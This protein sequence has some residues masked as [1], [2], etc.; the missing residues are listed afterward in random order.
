MSLVTHVYVSVNFIFIGS[1]NGLPPVE[2]QTITR[3]Y[4]DLISPGNKK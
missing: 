4:A 1:D 3:I 2:R